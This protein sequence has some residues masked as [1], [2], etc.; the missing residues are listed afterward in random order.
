MSKNN[1]KEL[2]FNEDKVLG[3]HINMIKESGMAKVAYIEEENASEDVK[4]VY[5]EIKKKFGIDFAPNIFKAMAAKP[6]FLAS[7]WQQY[8]TVMGPGELSSREKELIALAV[9][10]TNNCEYCI[11]AHVAALKRMGLSEEGI[12][13][14]MGVVGLYNFINKYLDGLMV[15]PD[16]GVS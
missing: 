3:I 7:T 13:E 4:K 12:V 6:E 5:D 9:S 11:H 2:L 15:E 8:K 14:L 1:I 16:I 10:A